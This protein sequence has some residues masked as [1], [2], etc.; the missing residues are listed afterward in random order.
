MKQPR[1]VYN[2]AVG[3]SRKLILDF[4]GAQ[5][6][7]G[8]HIPATFRHRQGRLLPAPDLL[9]PEHEVRT[10]SELGGN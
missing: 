9:A 6:E 5:K 10:P 8:L 1:R 2:L 4:L 7:L 3:G